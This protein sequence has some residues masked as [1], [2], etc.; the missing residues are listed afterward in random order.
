MISAY[1]CGQRTRSPFAFM[2]CGWMMLYLLFNSLESIFQMFF[3]LPTFLSL[4]AIF[5]L[6][7]QDTAQPAETSGDV[8]EPAYASFEDEYQEV[9]QSR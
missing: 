8:H 7:H 3:Q 2:V 9:L 4:I 5:A 6:L 1:R